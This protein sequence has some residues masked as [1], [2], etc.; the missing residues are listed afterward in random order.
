MTSSLARWLAV[1][2]ASAGAGA[3]LLMAARTTHPPAATVTVSVGSARVVA[4]LAVTPEEHTRGL[5]GRK[6]LAEGYGMLFVFR[7]PARPAF[8]M[9]GMQFPLDLIWIANGRVSEITAAV[10]VP[11]PDT[12]PPQY[13]PDAQAAAVLEVPAGFAQRHGVKIGSTAT[14][15]GS[16]FSDDP[17]GPK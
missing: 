5:S 11:V 1:G 13:V 10:P 7:Q 9:Q 17:R 4:E 6:S 3:L 16:G 14:W 2:L 12:P 15:Y 8:W